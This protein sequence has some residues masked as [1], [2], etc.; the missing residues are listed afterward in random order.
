[1]KDGEFIKDMV[2]IF[3]KIINHP[4]ILEKKE[5]ENADLIHK[6]LRSL[7]IEG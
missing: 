6:I 3:R 4:G 5:F 7:T 1:M 2:Q